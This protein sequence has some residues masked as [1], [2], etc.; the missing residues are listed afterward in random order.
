MTI[1][2]RSVKIC[3]SFIG[4][5]FELPTLTKLDEECESQKL[6]I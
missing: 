5:R 2:E 4:H 6:E 1:R 3:D